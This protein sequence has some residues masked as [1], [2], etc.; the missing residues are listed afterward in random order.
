MNH[1]I[2]SSI[3]PKDYYKAFLDKKLRPDKRELTEKR[4][5]LFDMDIL[6]SEE[7]SCSTSLGD[8]NRVLAVLKVDSN[9]GSN[10]KFKIITDFC[11]NTNNNSEESE[12]LAFTDALLRDNIDFVSPGDYTLHIRFLMMDG[13]IYDT[14]SFLLSNFF[15]SNK[16]QVV[17]FFLNQKLK[18]K[19]T[20][21][22]TTFS[23]I[24]KSVVIDPTQDE[25]DISS[26]VFNVI[27]F[28]SG[29]FVLHK[30]KGGTIS[31][32]NLK[33]IISMNK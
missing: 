8:G 31:F 18:L 11:G 9:F 17:S 27:N 24:C 3:A 20:F 23:Q 13:N 6:D 28:S 1:E 16:L 5:F 4:G 21:R 15:S 30:I 33:S 2:M 14:V 32:E 22:T 25:I 12:L 19:D 26:S 29:K 7:F 10:S